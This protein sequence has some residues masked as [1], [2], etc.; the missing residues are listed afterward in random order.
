MKKEYILNQVSAYYS[1]KILAFGKTPKGVDWNSEE[2][3]YLRFKQLSKIIFKK[4][5]SILDYGCGYGSLY[6]FLLQEKYLFNYCGY[7]ISEKMIEEARSLNLVN[8]SWINELDRDTKFNYVIA[9][10]IF[11]VKLE[12]NTIDW[13]E[14]IIDVLNLMNEVSLDGFSFNMLTSYS[15]IPLM[16]QH[17]YYGNPGFFFDYCKTNFSKNVSLLHDYDLYEFTI[18]VKK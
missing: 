13:L 2:S 10:G 9:S 12:N 15:D 6:N 18:T 8:A 16:K 11:N 1:D 7:D 14:Y 4:E 17:L 3:Q 5:F